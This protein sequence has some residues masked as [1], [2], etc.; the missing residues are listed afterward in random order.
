MTCKRK[1]RFFNLTCQSGFGGFSKYPQIMYGDIM[2]GYMGL[3][4]LTMFNSDFDK[5]VFGGK[6]A[7]FPL[8]SSTV[9]RSDLNDNCTTKRNQKT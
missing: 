7:M 4:G 1:N 2:H 9:S 5:G 6:K 8:T 3:A